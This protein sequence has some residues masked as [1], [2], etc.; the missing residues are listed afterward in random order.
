[1][2]PTRVSFTNKKTGQVF[3]GTP[4]EA[5]KFGFSAE[6]IQSKL[7]ATKKFETTLETGDPFAFEAQQ[8]ISK[9]QR[10]AEAKKKESGLTIS[11]FKGVLDDLKKDAQSV[12][13]FSSLKDLLGGNVTDTQ[14]QMFDRRKKLASQFLA[15]LVEQGRLSDKD[16]E[17]YQKE[18]TGISPY[19]N[20]EKKNQAIDRLTTDVVRLSGYDPAEFGIQEPKDLEDGGIFK[21]LLSPL[22]TTAGNVGA[23]GQVGLSSLVGKF[24][25]QAGAQLAQEGQGFIG[26]ELAKRQRMASEQPLQAY[27]EQ[28]LASGELALPGLLGM[29]GKIPAVSR[30]TGVVKGIPKAVTSKIG[31]VFKSKPA[32]ISESALV[33]GLKTAEKGGKVRDVAIQKAQ[34]AGKKIE[35]SKV[36]KVIESE[37]KDAKSGLTSPEAKQVDD[38]ISRARRFYKGKVIN[39]ETAK[40][41]WDLATKG[42]K[43]SGKTG[44][45]VKSAYHRAIRDGVRKE[46]DKIAPGFEKG[47]KAIR[48]GL[49]EE[50]I[51]KP[52]R[53]GLERKAIRKGLEETPSK[54]GE[55]L[56][57][58]G[59]GAVGAATTV[60][61]LRLLGLTG[62]GNRGD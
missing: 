1:M 22:I 26:G 53:T 45:T 21:S 19:G 49:E 62:G 6:K 3:S 52:I 13:V 24:N 8:E 11:G 56:K 28:A 61:L 51:L 31:G 34:E 37:L 25:P 35:G 58:Y 60:A 20:T 50:K 47:T 48:K 44:D 10:K 57:R 29:A 40:K 9:E 27:G 54:A 39:P 36:F 2:E 7:E 16:R 4:E 41:R 33:K 30:A 32:E 5:L 14:K 55:L 46:L 43:D 17:F 15:K 12:G 42:F 23:L 38:L 59:G 18:I